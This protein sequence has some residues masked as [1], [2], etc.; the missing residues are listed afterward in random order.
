MEAQVNRLFKTLPIVE[1]DHNKYPFPLDYWEE[2][3]ESS[4][5]HV[6]GVNN[7]LVA[8]VPA[9]PAQSTSKVVAPT[10]FTTAVAAPASGDS[11]KNVIT[12]TGPASSSSTVPVIVQQP[13]QHAHHVINPYQIEER[14]N[15]ATRALYHLGNKTEKLLHDK[16][17]CDADSKKYFHHFRHALAVERA[18]EIAQK[19]GGAGALISIS[20]GGGSSSSAGPQQHQPFDRGSGGPPGRDQQNLPLSLEV[21]ATV[22][23]SGLLKQVLNPTTNTLSVEPAEVERKNHSKSL[24]Q[25]SHAN[26]VKNTKKTPLGALQ[27][28]KFANAISYSSNLQ[29]REIRENDLL[30][31]SQSTTNGFYIARVVGKKDFLKREFL[32]QVESFCGTG[33]S[34]SV[35]RTSSNAAVP[36]TVAPPD[37]ANNPHDKK[38][39]LLLLKGTTWT[40]VK[41]DSVV[42]DRQVTAL[43]EFCAT[44]TTT[45]SGVLTKINSAAPIS[46]QQNKEHHPLLRQ[47]LLGRTKERTQQNSINFYSSK[48]KPKEGLNASQS[49]AIDSALQEPLTII[50]GPPGTGKTLTCC[51]ILKS[52]LSGIVA[53]NKMDRNNANSSSA[54]LMGQQSGRRNNSTGSSGGN[55]KKSTTTKILAVAD[56]NIAADNLYYGLKKL[57]L[58]QQT[59]SGSSSTSGGGQLHAGGTLKQ[60]QTP[61]IAR[62]GVNADGD[63]LEE[64]LKSHAL[65]SRLNSY[66]NNEENTTSSGHNASNSGTNK[67]AVEIAKLRQQMTLDIAEQ[68]IVLISTSV[69]I[70]NPMFGC[71]NNNSMGT[72]NML[73]HSAAAEGAATGG[74]VTATSSFV[75]EKIL[76]DECTQATEVSSLVA[77]TKGG[78]ALKS[79]VLA[80]DHMQLPP[81][82][83]SRSAKACLSLSLFERLV[84]K[85]QY[86]RFFL[87][88]QYRMRSRK[89]LDF[90]N[91][92]FYGSKLGDGFGGLA[93]EGAE[94]SQA[95]LE[96]GQ[97]VGRAERETAPSPL[98]VPAIIAAREKAATRPLPDLALVV[99]DVALVYT[100]TAAGPL[101][102]LA[103]VVKDRKQHNKTPSGTNDTKYLLPEELRLARV[104]LIN[105]PPQYQYP[106]QSD[107]QR[108]GTSK[109]NHREADAVLTT[110]FSLFVKIMLADDQDG[111]KENVD[112]G[113][114]TFAVLTAYSA[115]KQ[116]LQR[117]FH[118][119]ARKRFPGYY[120]DSRHGELQGISIDPAQLST[121]LHKQTMIETVDGCQG[122][123]ADFVLFSSVRRG[124]KLGFL[125]DK[126]RLNVMLS[127]AK[128][129]L[130]VFGDKET[131]Q[132]YQHNSAPESSTPTTKNCTSSAGA[133]IASQSLTS[134]PPL[135]EEDEG[136]LLWKKWV[137]DR[138]E[139][140]AVLDL[141]HWE[142]K[143]LEIRKT[144]APAQQYNVTNL[145]NW[146]TAAGPGGQNQN[147]NPTTVAA[148]APAGAPFG[149]RRDPRSSA[150]GSASSGV[151][152]D[153]NYFSMQN[154]M[155]RNRNKFVI[156]ADLQNALRANSLNTNPSQSKTPAVV[157]VQMETGG[158]LAQGDLV[159]DATPAESS[160]GALTS[161]AT[162]HSANNSTN[163]KIMESNMNEKN[164]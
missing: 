28:M 161:S 155:M 159:R 26:W 88:T 124:K 53:K 66:R 114:K 162:V 158:D 13:P 59:T 64:Q 74:G 52:W 110:L 71:G 111:V 82:V 5:V 48:A 81:T 130:I 87:D 42:Y 103:L 49:A 23:Q 144:A 33:S 3:V 126:R 92:E 149:G 63:L 76:I 77:L 68:A 125:T 7:M 4:L 6:R 121:L 157:G 147:Q 72:S 150:S 54:M 145:R 56:T 96:T 105:I 140:N 24:T 153:E 102:D 44:R 12:G 60:G 151:D 136:A 156:T 89:L 58:E 25:Q 123:E 133:I 104:L 129:G 119:R 132:A 80:G 84:S 65:Y 16:S 35:R 1:E 127:R 94:A 139:S 143:C 85:L 45:T 29:F 69:G 14:Y 55:N 148:Q 46:A 128:S 39:S 93:D 106:N 18:Q 32:I 95:C 163:T 2:L 112:K 43:H 67:S 17:F 83:V 11:S 21:G 164:E 141:K 117:L 122:R 40:A 108:C 137:E 146:A 37:H 73:R 120:Q 22:Y 9:A 86:G 34:T 30:V 118:Q 10:S 57:L 97:P 90:V 20:S 142:D 75:F 91:K 62:I 160:A 98:E 15:L 131:L 100:F 51:R 79:L 50:Q 134:N 47:I 115:Q 109:Q 116:L 138:V 154:S 61:Q 152:E 38:S 36:S 27:V 78:S 31:L 107:E 101:P 70:A 41:L 99:K 135:K 19:V 8:A 113:R